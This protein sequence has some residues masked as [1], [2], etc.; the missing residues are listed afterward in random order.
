MSFQNNIIKHLKQNFK[1]KNLAQ[2][3]KIPIYSLN[4]ISLYQM[5][6]LIEY[7]N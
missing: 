5:T 6:K 1:L 4:Q 7:I 2:Q 3:R